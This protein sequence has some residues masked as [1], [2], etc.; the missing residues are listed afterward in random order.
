MF[1]VSLYSVFHPA[2]LWSVAVEP[3]LL[4]EGCETNMHLFKISWNVETLAVGLS[5]SRRL[6][7][8]RRYDWCSQGSRAETPGHQLSVLPRPQLPTALAVD[9][10]SLSSSVFPP[11]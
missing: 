4:W 11:T 1:H 10:T 7:I 5:H 6:G 2:S 8:C 3:R 9:V